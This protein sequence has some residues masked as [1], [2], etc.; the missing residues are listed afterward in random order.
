[1]RTLHLIAGAESWR[2][3]AERLVALGTENF[4]SVVGHEIVPLSLMGEDH[5]NPLFLAPDDTT[6]LTFMAAHDV[7]CDFVGNANRAR[8]VE[9][10]SDRGHVANC[11]IDAAAVELNRSSL[12]DP[13]SLCCAPLIHSATLS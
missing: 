5:A 9:R 11:A 1:M 8:H 12:K 3:L 13:L 4:Y 2:P 6:I 7:Q 10:C